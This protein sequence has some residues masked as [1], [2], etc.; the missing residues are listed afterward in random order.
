MPERRVGDLR[1]HYEE[2]GDGSPLLFIHGLGSSSR[3]WEYQVP[4][5]A[6]AYRVIR[7]DLR[8][9]GRSDKPPGP[10][11]LAQF[12]ADCAALLAT[13]QTGPVHVVG[14][15]MGGMVGFQLALDAPKCVRSLT[16]VNSAPE[17]RLHGLADHL[18]LWQ[19]R[20]IVRLLGMRKLGQVLAARLFPEPGQA[21][22][23]QVFAQRWAEND[24]RAYRAS[25]EAMLGWSVTG[26]LGEIRCPV[27][28]VAAEHDY[29]PVATKQAYVARLP[30]AELAVVGNARHALPMERPERFNPILGA[31]LARGG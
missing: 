18:K 5:F 2:E 14:V 6:D 28:V 12:A 1:L 30:R 22:L 9:H 10:Y 8:G 21:A 25:L 17:L 7:V 19:R 16:V 29:T 20:F 31:F 24:A 27:L 23:R 13:L 26:R 11:S 15:S 3:D 4:A